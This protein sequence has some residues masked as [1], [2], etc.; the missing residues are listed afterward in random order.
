MLNN[1]SNNPKIVANIG[2]N[3]VS[4]VG[5]PKNKQMLRKWIILN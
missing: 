5:H 1:L 4:N 3:D 2:K